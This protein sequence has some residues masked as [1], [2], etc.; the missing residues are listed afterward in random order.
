MTRVGAPPWTGSSKPGSPPSVTARASPSAPRS[1]SSRYRLAVTESGIN[2]PRSDV[3][4]AGG[5]GA[6]SGAGATTAL[7][8]MWI[9]APVGTYAGLMILSRK[10]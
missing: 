6:G 3:A 9:G 10:L 1:R 8:L 7:G 4:P 2:N 5:G